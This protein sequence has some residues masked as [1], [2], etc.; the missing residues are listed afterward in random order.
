[1]RDNPEKYK[2]I[3]MSNTAI[4]QDPFYKR[5]AGIVDRAIKNR[6]EVASLRSTSGNIKS[7]EDAI[8]PC[9]Y[10]GYVEVAMAEVDAGNWPTAHET[11]RNSAIGSTML[12]LTNQE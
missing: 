6:G 7:F 5:A 10:A 11:A 1:L 3:C 12:T 4:D 8:S 2:D 9:I